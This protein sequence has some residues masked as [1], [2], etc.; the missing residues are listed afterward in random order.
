MMKPPRIAVLVDLPR[1]QTAG[2]HVKY[3][4]R[5]AMACA[6]EN[7]P[8]DLTVYFSGSGPDEILSPRVKFRHLSPVFS[9]ARLK[10]LPYVPA[11]TDLAPFHPSLRQELS[12]YDVLH[13]TDGYFAFARTAER[14]ARRYGI[15]L[16]SSFHTDTPAYAELFTQQTLQNL[17]G[18]KVGNKLDSL[19]KISARQ[20][21]SKEKRLR[22]HICACA[23]VLAMRPDDKAM[24]REQLPA[25][26]I[27][28][29]RMGVDKEIFTQNPEARAEIERDY[30]IAPGKFL[31]LFVG[32][33][34][35]GK[36]IPLLLRACTQA[37]K[38]GTKL[39]LII[40]GL[41]PMSDAAK[42]VLG[43]N[44]TLTGL[45]PPERL[46]KLYAAVD[47]LS[48]VSDIE[49]GGLVGVEALSCG[50]PV[51]ASRLSGIASLYGNTPAIE[52]VDSDEGSWANALSS[53]AQNQ[54]QQRMMRAAAFAFRREKL[55][56]WDVLLKEDFLPLWQSVMRKEKR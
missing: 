42:A 22:A 16:V 52:E 12:R 48:M 14:V 2:G 13:A 24:A 17:M 26:N 39:H 41:G 32:R 46:A 27:V 40:A 43:D 53:L 34:D 9:T 45:L 38:G 11:H 50:C 28:S 10:F 35:A 8:I 47:C 56:G 33:V 36:N 25:E 37:L 51:L 29:L 1:D 19:L 55:A 5:L 21:R 49:I 23:A 31:T 30:R 20:R 15:P 6:K 3:W 54:A 18:K 44:V 7:A 4:E